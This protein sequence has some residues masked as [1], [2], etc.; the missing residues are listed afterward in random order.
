VDL[1]SEGL[2]TIDGAKAVLLSFRDA[3]G[4]HVVPFAVSTVNGR[5]WIEPASGRVLQ[6]ELEFIMLAVYRAKITVRYG[7]DKTLDTDVP[8][9]MIDE[10]ENRGELVT[11][12]AEYRNFKKVTIDPAAFSIKR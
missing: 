7:H 6:T 3:P 4:G 8:V 12:R 9:S 10:Y 2:K 1:K 5:F 11:G